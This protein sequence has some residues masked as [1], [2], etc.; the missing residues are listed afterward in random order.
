[1]TKIEFTKMVAA[2]NDFVIIDNMGKKS[3]KKIGN[4]TKFAKVVCE[5]KHSI[6]ADGL[7]VL[8]PPGQ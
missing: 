6:G 8:E 4:L 1:M 7:L 5:R 2:G 3:E